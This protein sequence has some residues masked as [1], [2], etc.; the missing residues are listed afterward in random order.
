MTDISSLKTKILSRVEKVE[1]GYGS[2]CWVSDRATQPNGY[3][4][5]TLDGRTMLTHRVAYEEWRG[6]IADGL[7]IDHL[8]RVRA[9]CNPDHLEP[10][11]PQV[12]SLRGNSVSGLASRRTHCPKGHPLSG[13]N[14][15]RRRDKPTHRGCLTCRRKSSNKRAA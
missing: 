15:Y 7:Q 8:C 12:N 4:K 13:D 1:T 9:C 11:T 3:T 2:P 14:L 6:P 10:V 5:I